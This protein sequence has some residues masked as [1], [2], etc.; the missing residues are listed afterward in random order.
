MKFNRYTKAALL[1]T[2]GLAL[3]ASNGQAQNYVVDTFDNS[4]QASLFS[5]DYGPAA[6]TT[7][8]STDDANGNASSGSLKLT[9]TYTPTQAQHASSYNLPGSVD[10]SH[11]TALEFDVK[12]DPASALDQY[13]TATHFQLDAFV[14]ANYN[15]VGLY[16]ADIAPVSTNNGWQHIVV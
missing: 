1:A 16:G 6:G 10:L 9:I 11:A 15:F 7:T 14:T 2:V 3:A 5:Y 4:A 12:V 8:F 13:G